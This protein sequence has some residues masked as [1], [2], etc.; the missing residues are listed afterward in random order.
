MKKFF[1]EKHFENLLKI[2][3]PQLRDW[4]K[5][6]VE[7][8]KKLNKNSKILDVGCGFGRHMEI[9]A[10]FSNEVVGVDNNKD[11][12]AKAKIDLK[13]VKNI[14]LLLQD[15]TK[16]DL[17]NNS[18][19]YVICMSN[20]FGNFPELKLKV[21]S[22]MKRVCKKEG[23]IIISVYSDNA[24]KIR[25]KDYEKLGLT[26]TKIEDGVIYIK[27]GI[28]TEEFSKK[29]LKDLFDEVGLKSK[30]IALNDISYLCELEK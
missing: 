29:K 8:L 24:E 11:M 25:K 7:Y 14:K 3:S 1:S 27:E 16:L 9:L 4:Y 15:A 23:K 30:I 18:F 2:S 19:D 12:I 5:K 13:G 10:P 20:T 21:L 6:E 22:E 28:I 17:E 26:I